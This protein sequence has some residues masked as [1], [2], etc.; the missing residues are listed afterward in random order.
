[1]I[2]NVT[3]HYTC[4][5]VG[6][7][8]YITAFERATYFQS[9]ECVTHEQLKCVKKSKSGLSTGFQ[10]LSED[11]WHCWAEISYLVILFSALHNSTKYGKH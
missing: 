5:M 9:H 3:L 4:S 7:L 1:M 6:A 8:G 2:Q 11:E 10:E